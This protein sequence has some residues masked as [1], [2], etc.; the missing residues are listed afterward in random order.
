MTSSERIDPASCRVLHQGLARPA[1]TL[2]LAL[3]LFTPP[4]VGGFYGAFERELPDAF[5]FLSQVFLILSLIAW[6]HMYSQRQGIAWVLDMGW[7]LFAAWPVVVP[8]YIL[9]REGRRGWS[10]IGLFCLTWFAALATG[11]AVGIWTRL[12]VVGG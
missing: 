1:A 6:F 8:Y 12:L 10:R 4:V 5:P 7:F 9:K 11:W 2:L 3:A